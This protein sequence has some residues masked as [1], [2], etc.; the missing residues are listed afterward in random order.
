[1]LNNGLQDPPRAPGPCRTASRNPLRTD[2]VIIDA[3]RG[4][5]MLK[6]CIND[7]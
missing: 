7:V 4:L 3:S 1:M 6:F 2:K 5:A